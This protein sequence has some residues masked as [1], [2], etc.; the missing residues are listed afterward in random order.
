M[1]YD[2]GIAER[3]ETFIVFTIIIAVPSLTPIFLGFFNILIILTGI[4]RF[5]KISI[6]MKDMESNDEE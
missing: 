3:T 4:R 2:S 6:Y 5:K 1:H